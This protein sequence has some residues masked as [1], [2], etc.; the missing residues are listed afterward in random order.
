MGLE[1]CNYGLMV[2]E[3]GTT[4]FKMGNILYNTQYS[5]I[6]IFHYSMSEAETQIPNNTQYFLQ[7]V[8]ISRPEITSVSSQP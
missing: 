7:I 6:P 5:I 3:G 1:Y 8:E 2:R 4:K